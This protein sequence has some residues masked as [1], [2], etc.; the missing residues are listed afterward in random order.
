MSDRRRGSKRGNWEHDDSLPETIPPIYSSDIVQQKVSDDVVV[1]GTQD[2]ISDWEKAEAEAVEKKKQEHK[3]RREALKKIRQV[4][5]EYEGIKTSWRD[6]NQVRIMIGDTLIWIGDDNRGLIPDGV[7][8][9]LLYDPS[10]KQHIVDWPEKFDG[11]LP[12]VLPSYTTKI[13]SIQIVANVRPNERPS[14]T[15]KSP[16]TK[17]RGTAFHDKNGQEICDG[18]KVKHPKYGTGQVQWNKHGY[19]VDFKRNVILL[20]T[21]Y[22]ELDLVNEELVVVKQPQQKLEDGVIVILKSEVARDDGIKGVIKNGLV[23]FERPIVMYNNQKFIAVERV[24][25]KIEVIGRVNEKDAVNQLENYLDELEMLTDDAEDLKKQLEEVLLSIESVEL[26]T[27][28]KIG[29][30]YDNV[31]YSMSELTTIV[32]ESLLKLHEFLKKKKG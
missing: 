21:I 13:P 14:L 27:G 7:K 19:Y 12:A 29:I 1:I 24:K 16:P 22:F 28:E 3:R 25:D 17:S 20:R 31:N 18:D 8:G 10:T 32:D 15:P 4:L 5:P 26:I 6:T 23:E 9:L 30:D 2:L 11:I